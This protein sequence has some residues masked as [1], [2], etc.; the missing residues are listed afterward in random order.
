MSVWNPLNWPAMAA[1]A[2]DRQNPK[3]RMEKAE[4]KRT[5]I[6][7]QMSSAAGVV[8]GVVTLFFGMTKG[9][10]TLIFVGAPTIYV[11]YNMYRISENIHKMAEQSLGQFLQYQQPT[12]TEIRPRPDLDK[13]GKS[14]KENTFYFGIFIDFVITRVIK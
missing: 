9:S 4:L 3:Y 10:S 2:I 7:S 5:A 6:Q 11:S 13:I 14:L 12:K 8:I 1:E